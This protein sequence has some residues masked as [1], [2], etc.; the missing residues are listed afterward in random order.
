MAEV[1][2]GLSPEASLARAAHPAGPAELY[3]SGF[4]VQSAR[5]VDCRAERCRKAGSLCK[6]EEAGG[7]TIENCSDTGSAYG[8]VVEYGGERMKIE[9][10]VSEGATRR[11][12][13]MVGNDAEVEVE[14]RNF[15]GD[16][17]PVLLGITDRLEFVDAPSHVEDLK[18]YRARGY[19]MRNNRIAIQL[20]RPMEAVE[21]HPPS[22]NSVNM[23]GV[24]VEYCPPRPEI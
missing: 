21:V 17:R 15:A 16:G 20:D 8:L 1:K 11:V 12:L 5:L 22:A 14:I 24:T 4:Y 6:N 13:Q 18:R 3:Q 23:A 19:A 2:S 10:F 9:E 7:L